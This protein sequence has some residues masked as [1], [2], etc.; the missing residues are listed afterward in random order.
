MNQMRRLRISE[1]TKNFFKKLKNKKA[2]K[3]RNLL[4]WEI[5]QKGGGKF[6][7]QISKVFNQ[8][9]NGSQKTNLW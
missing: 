4:F 3:K 1:K 5:F 8:E 2:P 6:G 7:A 9:I